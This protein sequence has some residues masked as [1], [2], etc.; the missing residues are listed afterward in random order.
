MGGNLVLVDVDG[1]VLWDR[2]LSG[3][4]PFTPTVGD[5]DGDGQLDIVVVAVNHDESSKHHNN[6]STGELRRKLFRQIYM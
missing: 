6:T 4:L 1:E 3:T 5:I 2:K